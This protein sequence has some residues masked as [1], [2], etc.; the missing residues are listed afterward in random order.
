MASKRFDSSSFVPRRWERA[1]RRTSHFQAND[2]HH[3]IS[4]IK[5]QVIPLEWIKST[6]FYEEKHDL[7]Y[8]S[9]RL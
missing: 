6:D 8:T 3:F 5:R 7:L 2:S 1:H 4:G 9:V